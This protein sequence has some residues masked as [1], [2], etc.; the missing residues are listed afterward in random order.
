MADLAAPGPS[1]PA[2]AAPP[3]AGVATALFAVAAALSAAG[4]ALHLLWLTGTSLLLASSVTILAL[5]AA[6]F[7]VA[8]VVREARRRAAARATL[9]ACLLVLSLALVAAPAWTLLIVGV[10]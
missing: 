10:A 9:A 3:L 4:A 1:L 5:L 2:S 8:E 6:G 7:A